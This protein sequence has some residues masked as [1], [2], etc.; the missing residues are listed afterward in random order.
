M[1]GLGVVDN[2]EYRVRVK[3]HATRL[4][5]DYTHLK[6]PHLPSLTGEVFS[7]PVQPTMLRVAAPAMAMA[8][9]QLRTV[10]GG[11]C[12]QFAVARRLG[13]HRW[14]PSVAVVTV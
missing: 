1:L 4:G 9:R 5:L 11:R 10:P 2:A 8:R 12:I 13:N 6:T 3:G 14:L 7:E